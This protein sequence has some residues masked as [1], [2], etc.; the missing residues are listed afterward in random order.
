MLPPV[1]EAE[2]IL[3]TKIDIINH[4]KNIMGIANPTVS[5]REQ[6]RRNCLGAP[7]PIAV[8]W[9]AENKIIFGFSKRNESKDQGWISVLGNIH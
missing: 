6:I 7:L 8:S 1:A 2:F 3:K 9:W 5:S 4:L